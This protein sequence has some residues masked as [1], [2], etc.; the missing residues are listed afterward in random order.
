MDIEGG[1]FDAL[2]AFVEAHANGDLPV[3]QLQVEI[4]AYGDGKHKDLQRFLKWWGALEAAGLRPFSLEPNLLHVTF[5]CSGPEVVE[6][7]L[8]YRLS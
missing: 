7:R 6:V 4:H 8:F 2:T 5:T 1:E 3:G